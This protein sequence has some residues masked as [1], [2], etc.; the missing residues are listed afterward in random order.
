MK[1]DLVCGYF[2]MG[3]LKPILRFKQGRTI[4][5]DYSVLFRASCITN[6]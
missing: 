6:Y 2:L 5:G 4:V 3:V 1:G